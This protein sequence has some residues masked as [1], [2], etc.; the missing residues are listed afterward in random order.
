MTRRSFNR[1]ERAAIFER[2]SGVCHICGGKIAVGDAWDKN[3][4]VAA[5]SFE[6]VAP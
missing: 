6:R 2:A 5:I 4:W 1:R 3:P